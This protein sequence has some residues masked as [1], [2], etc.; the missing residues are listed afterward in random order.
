MYYRR[1]RQ[2]LSAVLSVFF[3]GRTYRESK[4]IFSP[5]I[6]LGKP[7]CD[8]V[9]FAW[10][11]ARTAA[12]A[13]E[14][15]TGCLRLRRRKGP[16]VPWNGEQEDCGFELRFAAL[17][18]VFRCGGFCL[19]CAA[20]PL[21][22]AYNAAMQLLLYVLESGLYCA[23]PVF[24]FSTY[25]CG[26][27]LVLGAPAAGNQG[28]RRAAAWPFRWRQIWEFCFSSN[29]I[30]F[31]RRARTVCWLRGASPPYRCWA[32]SCLS[33]SASTR[34]RRSVTL[35]TYTGAAC[36]PSSAFGGICCLSPFFRSWWPGPLNAA[37]I[38]CPNCSCLPVFPTSGPKRLLVLMLWG[39][40]QKMVV[41]RLALL[42]GHRLCPRRRF[43]RL[44]HGGGHGAV[45]L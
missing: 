14:A 33:A 43:G 25:L 21:R 39:Y 13:C 42:A 10:K 45:L 22:A 36:P 28:R 12:A 34:F 3:S 17:L 16:V 44:G 23:H 30:I 2:R 31:L 7:A 8:M 19:L 18:C 40:I 15:Q 4:S 5:Y 32:C 29:I 41:D 38:S 24:A 20:A 11:A 9:S 1:W 35:W 6:L 26:R 27:A 37:A